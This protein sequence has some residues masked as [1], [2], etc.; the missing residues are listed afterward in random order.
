MFHQVSDVLHQE[1]LVREDLERHRASCLRDFELKKTELEWSKENN[2]SKYNTFVKEIKAR[3][4]QI[5]DALNELV[6]KVATERNI[7]MKA[8]EKQQ[9]ILTE[10][11]TRLKD[12][13]THVQDPG[14]DAHE[15]MTA[16]KKKALE[17]VEQDAPNVKDKKRRLVP[18]NREEFLSSCVKE[19]KPG[20]P[21]GERTRFL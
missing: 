7:H 8:I 5:M 1:K 10:A 11:S 2:L 9:A 20:T 16:I 18:F 19:S 17:E 4:Q 14:Q 6:D 15:E 21:Q 13:A 3:K 12:V